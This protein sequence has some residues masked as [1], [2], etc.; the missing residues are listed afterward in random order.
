VYVPRGI[1][2]KN[3]TLMAL[4]DRHGLRGRRRDRGDREHRPLHRTRRQPM[5]A[6][7]KGTQQIAFT[8]ISLTFL[9]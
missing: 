4:N 9:G 7:L 8:I 6:A 2:I 5:D 1:S 3:L